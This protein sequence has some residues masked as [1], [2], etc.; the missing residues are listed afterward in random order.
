MIHQVIPVSAGV[1]EPEG[2]LYTYLWDASEELELGKTRPL[3][4]MCPGGAY[5]RTSDREAEPMALTFMAMG[6]HVA[7]LRYSCGEGIHYPTALLQLAKSMKIIREHAQEW[8]VRKDKIIVQGCSAGGHLAASLG[9]FW[10]KK[11]NLWRMIGADAETVKPDGLLLSYPVITAGEFANHSSMEGLLGENLLNCERLLE[12]QSLEKHVSEDVPGN[13][14]VAHPDRRGCAG[15]KFPV[16]FIRSLQRS[17][18]GRVPSLSGRQAW[19]R[20]CKP[21]D[22]GTRRKRN[23][24][25]LRELD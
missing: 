18:A 19:F 12:E 20:P 22:H 13:I 7:V 9:V 2:K 6:Y 14:F 17:C 23:R 4:L 11:E 5:K 1:G 25:G 24:R 21:P 16:I 10:K 15:T 8:G 3:I